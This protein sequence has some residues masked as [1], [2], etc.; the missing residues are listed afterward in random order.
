A[1]DCLEKTWNAISPPWQRSGY[2]SF[3]AAVLSQPGTV[4]SHLWQDDFDRDLKAFLAA[5]RSIPD[6]IETHFGCDKPKKNT[7][8]QGL[9]PKE[10]QRRR[11]FR[12]EFEKR[13][14]PFRNLALSQERIRTIHTTGEAHWQVE[15]TDRFG[16]LHVG[17]LT[18]PLPA[19]VSRPVTQGED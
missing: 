5:T 13:F 1:S 11:T 17:T 3:Q 12:R 4:L 9:D 15:I 16:K 10:I 6:I 19:T 14:G 7:W 2:T 8:L 18:Q